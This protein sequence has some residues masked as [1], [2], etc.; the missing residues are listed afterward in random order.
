MS[1]TLICLITGTSR[2]IGR[3]L[4]R[5]AAKHVAGLAS[6]GCS[7]LPTNSA[8]FER[9]VDIRDQTAV[10]KF[11]MNLPFPRLDILINN[12][13]IF[14][15]PDVGLGS[16]QV[17]NVLDTLNVNA[18]GAL[19]VVRA[20]LPLLSCSTRPTILN[21][22][23]D[24]G[25]LSIPR[26]AGSY[27]YRMSKASINMLTVCLAAEFPAYRVLSVHPGHVRT[28]MGGPRSLV[29]P[30]VSAAGIWKLA[31]EPPNEG[32]FF[33]YRGYAIDW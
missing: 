3:A 28:R 12:A 30:M 23:S 25:S 10:E 20:A 13:G 29:D 2:G 8:L 6:M 27:G 9:P 16:L 17:D 4:A 14:P 22:S 19:R 1:G 5:L 33:D 11:M 15:D 18:V 31:V 26:A 32:H 7:N 21:L 24:M